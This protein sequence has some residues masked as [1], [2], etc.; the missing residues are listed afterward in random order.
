MIIVK[1]LRTYFFYKT[2][3]VAASGEIRTKYL[4]SA[5]R[6]QLFLAA[7]DIPG[8]LYTMTK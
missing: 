6:F 8:L 5:F 4:K 7:V 2:P 1:F 3:P